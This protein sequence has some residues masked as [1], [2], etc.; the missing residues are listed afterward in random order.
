[1]RTWKLGEARNLQLLRPLAPRASRKEGAL[2]ACSRAEL[3]AHTTPPLQTRPRTGGQAL[4]LGHA[5]VGNNSIKVFI[6]GFTTEPL[7]PRPLPGLSFGEMNSVSSL[8]YQPNRCIVVSKWS[9]VHVARWG[10]GP[11]NL[12]PSKRSW[13]RRHHIHGVHGVVVVCVLLRWPR[14]LHPCSGSRGRLASAAAASTRPWARGAEAGATSTGAAQ[15]VETSRARWRLGWLLRLC[16]RQVRAA[17]PVSRVAPASPN[18]SH[19]T[20]RRS[21][22]RIPAPLPLLASSSASSPRPKRRPSPGGFT[23][24][25][26]YCAAFASSSA[27]RVSAAAARPSRSASWNCR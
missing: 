13:A 25:I 22:R 23:P 24:F 14:S 11:V 2:S 16:E 9:V 7:K 10:H 17:A 26:P 4:G 20:H 21:G 5:T 8:P 27:L 12:E 15:R 3:N 18:A 6:R 1:V 19:A